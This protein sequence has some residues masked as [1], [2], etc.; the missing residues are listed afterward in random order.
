MQK[1]VR[2]RRSKEHRTSLLYVSWANITVTLYNV[3]A[4]VAVWPTDNPKANH[5]SACAMLIELAG[6]VTAAGC[7]YVCCYARCTNADNQSINWSIV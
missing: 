6:S 5:Y 1:A 2:V 3:Y 4:H 7:S